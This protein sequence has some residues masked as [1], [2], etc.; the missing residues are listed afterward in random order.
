[1]TSLQPGKTWGKKHVKKKRFVVSGPPRDMVGLKDHYFLDSVWQKR[2][3]RELEERDLFRSLNAR[4]EFADKDLPVPDE[5]DIPNNQ[6]RQ[7][8]AG[9]GMD[10]ARREIFNRAFW[11][12]VVAANKARNLNERDRYLQSADANLQSWRTK[13]SM[14]T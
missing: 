3:I 1:M 13:F 8:Y 10:F 9:Q 7:W 4:K 6:P 11:F 2:H 12:F 14:S 5:V